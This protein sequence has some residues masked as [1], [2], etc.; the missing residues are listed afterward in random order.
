MPA[1]D[2]NLSTLPANTVQAVMMGW[3]DAGSEFV[4]MQTDAT[5]KLLSTVSVSASDGPTAGAITSVNDTASDTT[6]LAANAARKG[7]SIFNDSTSILYLALANV[8][9]S[10]TVYTVQVQGGQF[11]ELP[12]CDG[13][14]YTGV[15][16][17]IWSA[18]ASGAARVTE[19]T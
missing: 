13:G 4:P 15:I 5:G 12:L 19:W 11:Y 9:S 6:I 16:K 10:T 3:Y 8:T 1:P 14:V 7:A 18:D 17:G 2:P